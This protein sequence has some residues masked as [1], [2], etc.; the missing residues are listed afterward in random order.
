MHPC[1]PMQCLHNGHAPF[2]LWNCCEHSGSQA[3]HTRPLEPIVSPE[4]RR[5]SIAQSRDSGRPENVYHRPLISIRQLPLG[6]FLINPAEPRPPNPKRNPRPSKIN[7]SQSTK[8][9]RSADN[10]L[11][12]LASPSRN[13]GG[14]TPNECPAEFVNA[15]N[16]PRGQGHITFYMWT[17]MADKVLLTSIVLPAMFSKLP[18]H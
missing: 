3:T 11:G 9:A 8:I 7:H 1:P 4:E 13:R 14:T 2:P 18:F 15:L 12:N 10:L 6:P 5:L 16:R 17:G